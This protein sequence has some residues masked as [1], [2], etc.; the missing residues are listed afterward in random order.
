[1]LYTTDNDIKESAGHA[2]LGTGAIKTLREDIEA[3]ELDLVN[4]YLGQAEY[5]KLEAA[6]PSLEDGSKY[7][8]LLKHVRRYVTA[9]SLWRGSSKINVQIDNSGISSS[10]SDTSK[11][12]REW[13]LTDVKAQLL[14]D[15]CEYLDMLL[16]F[17]ENNK[18]VYTDWA[19]STQ[20]KWNKEL[21]INSLATFEKYYSLNGSHTT[22]RNLRATMMYVDD[23]QMQTLLGTAF[24]ASIK[25]EISTA[26]SAETNVILN[27]FI[28]RIASFYTIG[29]A[30]KTMTVSLVNGGVKITEYLA[31]MESGHNARQAEYKERELL[32][33]QLEED[34]CMLISDMRKYLN[35]NASDT[36]YALW[37]DSDHYEDPNV[38]VEK[39]QVNLKSSGFFGM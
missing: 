17:L 13:M 6:L 32:G 35:A 31:Q 1:M 18:E 2:S 12:V 14:N 38:A 4:T 29:R 23:V 22:Y 9:K 7:H 15:A 5:D 16:S 34:A 10:M 37:K 39:I 26:V 36:V 11:P 8:K 28:Y 21:L 25:N 20:Y 24:Y 30:L 3:I 19:G 33:K 27:N